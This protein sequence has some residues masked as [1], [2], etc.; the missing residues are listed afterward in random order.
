M[1]LPFG[2]DSGWVVSVSSTHRGTGCRVGGVETP[3]FRT[4][5]SGSVEVLS[6]HTGLRPFRDQGIP[7]VI[8]KR[9]TYLL[10]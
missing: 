7:R 2:T 3:D 10:V 1:T 8:H 9:L 4:F 5:L 6:R